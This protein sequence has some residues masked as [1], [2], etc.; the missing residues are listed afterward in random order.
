MIYLA[1]TIILIFIG[2]KWLKSDNKYFSEFDDD[3]KKETEF[4]REKRITKSNAYYLLII[5]F[6]SLIMILLKV[7]GVI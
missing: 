5:G 2:F 4:K 6:F 3:K 7:L 1:L